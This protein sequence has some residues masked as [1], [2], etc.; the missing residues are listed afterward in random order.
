MPK[1]DIITI[2]GAT[3][4]ITFYTREGILIKNKK[5]ILR[6]K[7]L[8]F[9]YGAKIKIDKAHSTFGGGAAN[10]AACLARLNFRVA[11]MV[12]IG[13]D[14]RGERII[15]NFQKQGVNTSLVKKI[16]DIETGFSFLLV[17]PGNEH[18]VFSNRAAN[19]KLQI[20][21]EDL[22][23]LK[24][25]Q[26]IYLTSLSGNWRSVLRC[27][28][29]LNKIKIAWNPGHIQLNSGIKTIG[30]W[31]TK[32][33]VLVLNKDE[34]IELVVSDK[35]YRNSSSRFL[36]NIKNLLKILKEWGPNIMVIT[37]GRYGADAYDG[38][39]FY[40]QPALKEKRRVDTTGVGDAFGSTFIA[41]LNIYNRD[42]QKSMHLA[43]RNTASVIAKQGA[44]NGL[45][46]L[47]LTN[48]YS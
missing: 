8:A 44:Q 9:E 45:I 36:N 5:D 34:A 3:E 2:G 35:Q 39:N 12:A 42:I 29:S 20:T 28:F 25:C 15:A 48:S 31:L 22:N 14:S 38:V 46:K 37:N 10:A 32:T 13:D 4:D 7:L 6:Q 16:K 21:K 33:E 17:G 26:W 27:I 24:N 11:A 30:R 40:Y 41:G 47:R 1:Y 18:I 23:N 19:S 43:A